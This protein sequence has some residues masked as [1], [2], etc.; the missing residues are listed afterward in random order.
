[1]QFNIKKYRTLLK[2]KKMLGSLNNAKLE[3]YNYLLYL[4]D[5]YFLW[6]NKENF[7]QLIQLFLNKKITIDEFLSKFRVLNVSSLRKSQIFQKNFQK[8]AQT[9]LNEIEIEINPNSKGFE[10]IISYLNDI[11]SLY[12]PNIT[13]EM[14][15]ENPELIGY[16]MSEELIRDL[17]K[18]KF[19]SEINTYCKKH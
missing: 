16:G 15:L 5:D 18:D 11:L 3:I 9:N 6:Q 13:L 19:L 17:L 12:E 14:N 4:L 1:M 8:D 2:N 7:Y 10:K